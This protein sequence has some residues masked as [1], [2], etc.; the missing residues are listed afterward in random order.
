MVSKRAGVQADD[1]IIKCDHVVTGLT[2]MIIELMDHKK[3]ASTDV[4]IERVTG[5]NFDLT[6][7][8]NIVIVHMQRISQS[9]IH[10]SKSM[11]LFTARCMYCIF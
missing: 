8:I 9:T 2:S 1:L 3:R 7:A 6:T 4:A 11:Y 5:Y 10:L